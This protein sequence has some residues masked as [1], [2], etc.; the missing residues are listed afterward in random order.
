MRVILL[1][2]QHLIRM[3]PPG[4][5]LSVRRRPHPACARI[6]SQSLHNKAAL[7]GNCRLPPRFIVIWVHGDPHLKHYK[8]ST[9]FKANLEPTRRLPLSLRLWL[10][11]T[12]EKG[13]SGQ[14]KSDQEKSPQSAR[15]SKRNFKS[16]L[17]D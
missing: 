2:R 6:A 17:S 13:E 3:T 5:A 7:A 14:V 10:D 16:S 11:T 15:K 9:G 4:F 1:E 8:C 12:E